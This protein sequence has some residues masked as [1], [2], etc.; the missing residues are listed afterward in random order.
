MRYIRQ[1]IFEKIGA[2]KQKLLEKS[3]VA[4]VGIGAL[5]T[6]VSELLTRSGV[7]KL[8]LID[9]DVVELSNL[10]RQAL[11]NE[12]DVDK[13]KVFAAKEKLEKINSN[14]KIEAH[15]V[16]LDCEN[17]NLIKSDLVIDCTDNFETRFLINDFCLKENIPWIYGAVIGSHGMTLNIF[18]K[19]TPC[20]RCVFKEPT[21]LLGTCDTEGIIN[22]IPH[23]IA[24]IQVT[25]AIKILTKQAYNKELIY[26]DLWKNKITKTNV[27]K[28]NNC[29]SCNGNYEY[30][31]DKEQ[32]IV[33]MCGSNTYQIKGRNLELNE[34]FK[35][36][37]KLDKINFNENALFFKNLIVFRDGRVLVKTNSKEQAK[38]L[39]D[40]Y[41]G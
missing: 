37:E 16:D 24:G 14:V 30:L 6:V 3:S 7:K 22:T 2:E 17:I 40:K 20:F 10:Q 11:F 13:L 31:E 34:L 9:R 5:G 19:K 35:R 18:H 29:P 33:K 28:L 25:E 4:V 39:Y 26:Y 8:I 12:A 27:K 38:A 36:F 41:L 23:V 21:K 32:D 1:V 15:C